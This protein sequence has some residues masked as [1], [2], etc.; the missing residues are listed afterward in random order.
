MRRDVLISLL[1]GDLELLE[2]LCAEGLV[3]RDDDALR[4]EH[5]ETVRVVHT[6][7]HD[8]DINWPGVEVILRMR[9]ELVATRRQIEDLLALLRSGKR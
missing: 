9:S 2:R 3:P 5:A 7:V 4:P 6:L 8:L 1:E